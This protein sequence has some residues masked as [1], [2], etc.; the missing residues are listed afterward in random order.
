[1]GAT[2]R[3]WLK[4]VNMAVYP[5]IRTGLQTAVRSGRS[6]APGKGGIHR[7]G[8]SVWGLAVVLCL[9]GLGPTQGR[10]A[11]A[12]PCVPGLIPEALV[13]SEL[14]QNERLDRQHAVIVDKHT[15]Q[16]YLFANR[17]RWQLVDH[18]PC[19]TGKN[20]GRKQKEG[21]FRTPEGIYFV[22]R[23]V[24]WRYLEDTYGSYALPL[25]YPNWEDRRAH[26]SGSAIWIHGTNKELR[27]RDSNGCVVLENSS[28]EALAG[29]IRLYRTPVIIVPRLLWWPQRKADTLAAML[30]R[31]VDR[32]GKAMAGGSYDEFRNWYGP[33]S[34]PGM[35]WW[36]RWCRVRQFRGSRDGRWRL[37]VTNREIMKFQNEFTVLF[38]L[39]VE[40]AFARVWVGR[41]KLILHRVDGRLRIVGDTYAPRR[42]GAVNV[43]SR[44][45]LF[46]AWRKLHEQEAHQTAFHGAGDRDL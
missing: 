30:I 16:L 14:M 6:H 37:R 28:I 26:R 7:M 32:W 13:F 31:T 5:K 1:M 36:Q 8:Y 21:D 40:Q 4:A 24:S 11:D 43:S 18:W 9:A 10:A 27:D 22:T 45:P 2:G 39:Y 20:P 29:S 15:Q 12:S 19:S 44:D 42:G 17:G 34:A 33:R 35:Q 46:A 25:N 41:R 3:Q 23:K 38:D